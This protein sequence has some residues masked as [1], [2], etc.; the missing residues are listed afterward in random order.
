MMKTAIQMTATSKTGIRVE[1]REEAELDV[2]VDEP[3]LLSELWSYN[4]LATNMALRELLSRTTR[5]SK[6]KLAA[7]LRAWFRCATSMV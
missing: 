3:M 1:T 6:I 4:Q 7:R 5:F 2:P